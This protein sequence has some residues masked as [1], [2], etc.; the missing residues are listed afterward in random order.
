MRCLACVAAIVAIWCGADA[1]GAPG[2][3]TVVQSS[4]AGD[5]W[6]LLPPLSWGEDFSAA[7]DVTVNASA[8]HQQI[9]GF[10]TAM[11]DTSAYNS[12]VFMTPATRAEFFEALWGKTG[13]HYSVGRVT[14]N[15]ADYSFQS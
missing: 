5:T 8:L 4:A 2:T 15:S 10:G 6:K 1:A 13:L 11:T 14:L 3:V 7:L 9:L 12:V